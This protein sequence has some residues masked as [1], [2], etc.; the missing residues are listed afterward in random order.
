MNPLPL[1]AGFIVYRT[2][3]E[4]VHMSTTKKNGFTLIELLIAIAII[5]L[6]AT[7]SFYGI[8]RQQQKNR[9]TKRVA[10]LN[11]LA[12]ALELGFNQNNTY[13]SSPAAIN[14]GTP[15]LLVLCGQ[16]SGVFFRA[17]AGIGNCDA[18]KMYM[19]LVPRGPLPPPEYAYK[20]YSNDSEYCIET[21][22]E[23]GG[24]SGLDAGTISS[25][26]T[27]LVNGNCP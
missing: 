4:Y 2:V 20:S 23:V 5:G 8:T 6:L 13:P 18:D 9:D 27:G 1:E 15:S 3:L 12:K 17:D 19:T 7:I 22:L 10:D 11:Q 26:P 24:M 14:L 25:R 21:A 16:G